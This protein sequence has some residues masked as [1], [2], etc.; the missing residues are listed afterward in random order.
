V[1]YVISRD[2]NTGFLF[3]SSTLSMSHVGRCC[4]VL[5]MG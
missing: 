2:C 1:T 3:V 5:S 4:P